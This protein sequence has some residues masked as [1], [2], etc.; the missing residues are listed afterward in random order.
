MS[1][2]TVCYSISTEDEGVVTL[3]ARSEWEKIDSKKSIEKDCTGWTLIAFNINED[4]DDDDDE[5]DSERG[6]VY[7]NLTGAKLVEFHNVDKILKWS[8]PSLADL[9]LTALRD[10]WAASHNSKGPGRSHVALMFLRPDFVS[11]LCDFRYPITL[12]PREIQLLGGQGSFN[13]CWMNT[14]D[15]LRQRA[16]CTAGQAEDMC[17]DKEYSEDEGVEEDDECEDLRPPT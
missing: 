16:R 6:G 5:D 12:D 3:P 8:K 4:D 17:I 13:L 15:R 10:M 14:I 9:R 2:N 7:V 1:G 11:I